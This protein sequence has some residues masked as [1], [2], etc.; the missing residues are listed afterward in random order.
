MMNS[1]SVDL[2][3]LCQSFPE[4]NG[5]HIQ[6][7]NILITIEGMFQSNTN[8]VIIEGLEGAGKTTLLSQFAL[9]HGNQCF[10]TF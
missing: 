8:M 3:S 10:S 5:I 2:H 4:T 7:E 1:Q 9:R 6:R